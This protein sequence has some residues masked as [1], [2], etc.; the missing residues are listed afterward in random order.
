MQVID[1]AKDDK[2]ISSVRELVNILHEFRKTVILTD[3]D[4]SRDIFD[5]LVDG[6]LKGG[7][8]R[9]VWSSTKT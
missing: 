3:G 2:W 9:L 8:S 4:V 5:R 1:G 7:A 6:Q